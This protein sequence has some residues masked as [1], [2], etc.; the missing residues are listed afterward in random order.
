MSRVQEC[1]REC[2]GGVIGGRTV[3][4]REYLIAHTVADEVV[5]D[6]DVLAS[7]VIL[8]VDREC[9]RALIVDFEQCRHCLSVSKFAKK[10]TEPDSFT[11]GMANCHIFGFHA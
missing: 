10:T 5:A 4:K 8:R 1:L 2:V 11:G 7:C 3:L 6:V 9:D